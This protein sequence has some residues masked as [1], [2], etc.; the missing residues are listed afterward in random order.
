MS[1]S[2]DETRDASV[3][4]AARPGAGTPAAVDPPL[5]AVGAMVGARYRIVRSIAKGGMGEVFEA[6]DLELGSRIAIKTIRAERIGDPSAVAR[7]KLEIL[8]ARKITHPNVIRL[9]DVGFHV[10]DDQREVAF[11]TMELFDG[12]T[13]DARIR[14]AGRLATDEALSLAR[15]LASA[16]DAAHD[17]GVVHRDFKSQNVILVTEVGTDK[18][19]AA[20][21]TRVAGERAIITDFGLARGDDLE[22]AG[23]TTAE[24]VGTPAYM[25]PEQVTRSR[26]IGTPA[27]VYAFGVVLFEMVTGQWPFRGETPLATAAMRIDRE[28]PSPR[29]LV[30]DL[31]STWDAAIL[32]CLR[33]D[34]ARRFARASDVVAA[35]AGSPRR[36]WWIGAAAAIGATAGALAIAALG[37]DDGASTESV[38][39]TRCT[40]PELPDLF[41][42][43]A[44]PEGGNGSRACPF[45]TITDALA[46]VA[47]RRTIRIAAGFYDRSRGERFPLVVRGATSLHGAG[48]DRTS[49]A[50]VGAWDPKPSG[51]TPSF[52]QWQATIVTG[53]A[54]SSIE[55]ADLAITSGL[56]RP[57]SDV[58]GVMC[59]AGGTGA[60]N[61][62]LRRL[63][64]GPG[65]GVGIFAGT[66]TIPAGTGCNLELAESRLHEGTIG[67]WQVGCGL[68]LGRNPV[69]LHVRATTFKAFRSD[70]VYPG[71]GLVAYDCVRSLLVENS[72]FG[73]SEQGLGII[74]HKGEPGGPIVI[75]E[76]QFQALARIGISL[77]GSVEAEIRDNELLNIGGVGE[78]AGR[79][80]A[81]RISITPGDTPQLL[82]R[83][84]RFEES[85]VGLE[86][87]GFSLDTHGPIAAG[88]RIDAGRIDDPGN[89]TFRCNAAT[90]TAGV[91]GH[92]VAVRLDAEPKLSLLLA[93][94]RWDH[95]P[96]TRSTRATNGL[97]ILTTRAAPAIDVTGA[98]A[99]EIRCD[100]RRY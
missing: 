65:Y 20:R 69:G 64:V 90:E 50:G 99:H 70:A 94:N 44:A 25:A 35:L 58:A 89:N 55:I 81:L 17:A 29:S 86:I 18:A 9:F 79:A 47:D 91:T 4:G 2:A 83:G 54:T 67:I 85:D 5:F 48:A 61:T 63:V 88:A 71:A 97:D 100:G 19:G 27:D 12:E 73:D 11:F 39:P 76:N 80:A 77:G 92:D 28:P 8:A 6:E 96:P 57:Q 59:T 66:E 7:L 34:P 31:P 46:V 41:V 10:L 30:P 51:G 74:R 14:R 43:A 68:G 22:S 21:S 62:A 1:R 84:N 49:I 56:A 42:D 60:P 32:R 45:R 13:L 93:G 53:D 75:R 26:A 82:V 37:S 15:Q 23:T 78:R 3:D 16:L 52:T 72:A 24:F 87:A 33:R 38:T 40:A 98:R 95:A 36:R